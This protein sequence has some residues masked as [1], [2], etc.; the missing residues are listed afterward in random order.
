M[1]LY[2]TCLICEKKKPT[3]RPSHFRPTV[4]NLKISYR[5]FDKISKTQL[6]KVSALYEVLILLHRTYCHWDTHMISFLTIFV[7]IYS[8]IFLITQHLVNHKL[9]L[10][11]YPIQPIYLHHASPVARFLRFYFVSNV[12]LKQV[13]SSYFLWRTVTKEVE[14]KHSVPTISGEFSL[15]PLNSRNGATVTLMIE[16]RLYRRKSR[17]VT[18]NA[19]ASHKHH[20]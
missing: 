7:D 16:N 20:S 8:F 2:R 17:P 5:D 15:R 13:R 4:L 19:S 6:H 9:C 12:C 14:T 1:L 18:M 11:K 3:S 10:F